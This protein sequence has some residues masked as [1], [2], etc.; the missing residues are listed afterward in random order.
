MAHLLLADTSVWIDHLRRGDAD[1]SQA[2]N[3][4]RVLGHPMVTGEIAMGS[5]RDRAEILDALQRLAALIGGDGAAR[6]DGCGTTAL[7][8]KIGLRQRD[9]RVHGLREGRVPRAAVLDRAV[10]HA[11]LARGEPDVAGAAQRAQERGIFHLLRA[12]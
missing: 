10:F 9:C 1:L 2:L 12:G 7:R 11:A 3:D 6:R 5:L 8:L 4:G